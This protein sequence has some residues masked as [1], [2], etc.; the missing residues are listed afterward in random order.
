MALDD[1]NRQLNILD[2]ALGSLW[3]NRFKNSGV[4]LVFGLVIFII[5][6]FR[7]VTSSL[8]NAAEQL[9]TTVPDITVQKM[10]AGRQDVL[11][12]SDIEEITALFGIREIKPRIWGYY[13]DE[14]NGANYTVI[15]DAAFH[16]REQLPGLSIVDR[17]DERVSQG[18]SPV[19]VGQS[20]ITGKNLQGRSSFSLFR[21]DLSLKSFYLSGV[22]AEA[23]SLVSGDLMVMEIAAAA[24]LFAMGDGEL[25][26]I[27]V[28]VSNPTEI[29]T[30]AQKISERVP[31]SRVITKNQIHK[32]YRA[33]FGWRSGFGLV[34]LLGS[35]AAFV[36][37]AWDKASGLS[38]EQRRE[39]AILK[40]VGWQT[41]DV[42]SVRFWESVVISVLAFSIGYTL[43]WAHVL[44]FDGLLFKPVLLGWSVLHPPLSLL[45]VFHLA[46][47]ML[48]F[49]ISILPYLA[50]T[51][52]PAWRSA[53]IR[54]DS[55]V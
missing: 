27:V 30:I 49:S 38:E 23:T 8:D 3:R 29:D 45:P 20:V 10:T 46:D 34:C 5:A 19:A 53:L 22:F 36:I 28:S 43:A 47:L 32:T 54:P 9:L 21:P 26:D 51:V 52:I 44:W 40:A 25:T 39:V 41:A 48:I 31:G 16:G 1:L 17:P 11:H 33:V 12:Y 35:V 7:L 6:S 4:L 18:L 37:L 50:A 24:D 14:V 15:G 2:Y 13:F 55:I 42:M